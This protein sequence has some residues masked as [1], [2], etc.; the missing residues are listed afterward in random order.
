MTEK[1]GPASGRTRARRGEVPVEELP[2]EKCFQ[3]LE[4]I[5]EALEKENVS[6]DES[7]RL[8]ERGMALS[9]RC[10]RELQA[11]EQRIEMIVEEADGTTRLERFN[12]DATESPED[13]TP[14]DH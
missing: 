3:E 11:I 4:R 14:R 5:V 1:Q 8:F 10:M 7:L 12:A 9:R 13:A 2:L 6:L